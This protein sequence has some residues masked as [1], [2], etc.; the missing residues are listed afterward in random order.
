MVVRSPA[1][2]ASIL[3]RSL[4]LQNMCQDYMNGD[5]MGIN[6]RY[7]GGRYQTCTILISAWGSIWGSLV[8]PVINIIMVH[9][10]G[11]LIARTAGWA[12]KQS[13]AKSRAVREDRERICFAS[14]FACVVS[15]NPKTPKLSLT[16]DAAITRGAIG[17]LVSPLYI[18]GMNTCLPCLQ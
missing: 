5:G 9:Q 14:A 17:S 18:F 4:R 13:H 3:H 8:F 6:H 12:W 1:Y 2:V 11:K 15:K 7:R 16:G 10:V